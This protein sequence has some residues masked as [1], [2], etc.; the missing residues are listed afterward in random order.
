[1]DIQALGMLS[2]ITAIEQKQNVNTIEGDINVEKDFYGTL[3]EQQINC[4]KED[5]YNKF[6]IDVGAANGYFE[7]YIPSDVLYKMN[8]DTA[9]RQENVQGNQQKS[10]SREQKM[11]LNMQNIWKREMQNTTDGIPQEERSRWKP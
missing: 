2:N 10:V 6:H 1:M 11:T 5:I 9:L 8:T 4:V 3:R 7:C